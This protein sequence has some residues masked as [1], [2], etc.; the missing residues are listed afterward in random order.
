M[1]AFYFVWLDFFSVCLLP[2]AALGLL[3][4]LTRPAN[5]SVD[6]D[7]ARVIAMLFLIRIRPRDRRTVHS[8]V[9]SPMCTLPGWWCAGD[10]SSEICGADRYLAYLQIPGQKICA[11]PIVCIHNAERSLCL[12]MEQHNSGHR[13]WTHAALPRSANLA[14]LSCSRNDRTQSINATIFKAPSSISSLMHVLVSCMHAGYERTSPITGEK[15]K[16]YEHWKRWMWHYPI[17]RVFAQAT[18]M[19]LVDLFCSIRPWFLCQIVQSNWNAMLVHMH[20]VCW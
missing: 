18:K 3:T 6:N 14:H 5:E 15:E 7:G 11:R 19:T 9:Q 12:V 2:P 20:T 17:R 4:W 8:H 13:A 1:K 10:L 16:H